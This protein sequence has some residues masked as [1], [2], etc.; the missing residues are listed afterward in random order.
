MTTTEDIPEKKIPKGLNTYI[1]AL[2]LIT[3]S[4]RV[5]LISYYNS[6][7]GGIEQNVIYGIQRIL[8]GQ[9][10]YQDPA[11]GTYAVMQYTPLY[12]HFTASIA[13]LAGLHS[14]D[15][16]GIY[17][18]C[19]ILALTFNLLTVL[20]V[21][22]IIRK[23]RFN[24]PTSILFS[25]PVLMLLTSHYYTRGDSMH[26]FLFTLAVSYYIR[27]STDGGLKQIILAALFSAGCIMVK[28]SGILI[29]GI[30]CA[31]LMFA[32]RKYLVALF[33]V[34]TSSLCTY[35][36]AAT[37]IGN[38]WHVFYQNAYLG[39]MD[40]TDLSFL[41]VIFTSQFFL[42]LVPC[43]V[44]GGIMVLL[45][46]S[47]IK[48]K[49]YQVLSIGATLSFLFAVITGLKIGSSNNYFTEFLVFVIILLPY[50]LHSRSGDIELLKA[51]GKVVTISWFAYFAFI[52]LITSKTVGL[53]TSVYIEERLKNEQA[54]YANEQELYAYMKNEFRL[55]LEDR[56]FFT[57]RKFF[58]NIFRDN[59]ILP[60]KDVVFEVYASNHRTYDYAAFSAGM[61]TGMIKYIVTDEHKNNINAWN[62]ELPFVLF[63]KNKF[64]L[65]TSHS[66]YAIYTYSPAPL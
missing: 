53:F 23:W 41:Y 45:A 15:V 7:Y 39:L 61:N 3:L 29:A 25:L 50:L 9:A 21:A 49:T 18:L 28:Q 60:N 51:F 57:E 1:I 35:L 59:A 55:T 10:L 64:K 16:H 24:W 46:V 2:F 36:I 47:K 12:Y 19:R 54:E 38:N 65:L 63:D 66:G 26:L 31:G 40:G 22:L 20:T 48:D 42:D 44:L 56:I 17:T 58:D 33:Y 11:A 27:Y 32:E 37:C 5:V 4:I 8:A 52:I 34:L 13:K 62:R 30:I 43:Y 6:N 14:S